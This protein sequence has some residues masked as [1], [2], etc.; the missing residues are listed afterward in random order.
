MDP[1][2]PCE[3]PMRR[4]V[5]CPFAYMFANGLHMNWFVQER[6]KSGRL[7]MGESAQFLQSCVCEDATL[8]YRTCIQP[9]SERVEFAFSHQGKMHEKMNT[10]HYNIY[11][12]DMVFC[13]V[14]LRLSKASCFFINSCL[15][16][17]I[18]LF[19]VAPLVLHLLNRGFKHLRNDVLSVQ[20]YR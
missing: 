7:R 17:E 19:V 10:I 11:S 14:I 1:G 18:S 15:S 6:Q 12:I 2:G 9:S 8:P 20:I 3:R 4:T 13:R 16:L 5:P